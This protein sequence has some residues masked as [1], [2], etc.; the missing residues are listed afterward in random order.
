M[1]KVLPIDR[2]RIS[3]S[4]NLTNLLYSSDIMDSHIFCNKV[5][6]IYSLRCMPQVHGSSRDLIDFA[7]NQINIEINSVSDNPLVFSNSSIVS[8]GHFHAETV[9][10]SLDIA[11]ISIAS[12]SNIS[13]KQKKNNIN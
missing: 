4:K 12:L 1:K 3:V 13:V 7:T 8:A 9:A 2:C 11:A 10:H 5:Q 6:D